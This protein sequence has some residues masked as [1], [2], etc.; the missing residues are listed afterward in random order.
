MKTIE[1]KIG[2]YLG[3]AV[4]KKEINYDGEVIP[5]KTTDDLK[6][7][8]KKNW[9]DDDIDILV[10]YILLSVS[11]GKKIFMADDPYVYDVFG[12]KKSVMDHNLRGLEAQIDDLNDN[13]IERNNDPD[14]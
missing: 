14:Y 11:K 13:V 12:E 4:G 7:I 10:K 2:M 3:E 8:I 5:F 1:E 6:K 9:P